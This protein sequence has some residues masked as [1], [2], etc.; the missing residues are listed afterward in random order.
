M[1]FKPYT[2]P[3]RLPDD[4]EIASEGNDYM[5]QV[6]RVAAA[7]AALLA[8][9]WQDGHTDRID[10]T[11]L[12]AGHDRWAQLADA[13]QFAMAEVVG[14]G[15][16]VAWPDGPDISARALATMAEVQRGWTG[17]EFSAWMARMGLS[18]RSAAEALA[19]APSTIHEQC[20]KTKIDRVMMLAARALQTDGIAFDA[21]S[22]P[23]RPGRP[24]R[25]TF[26]D[27]TSLGFSDVRGLDAELASAVTLAYIIAPSGKLFYCA[28]G[29]RLPAIRGEAPTAFGLAY[30]YRDSNGL[31]RQ[32]HV[33]LAHDPIKHQRQMMNLIPEV[34][35]CHLLLAYPLHGDVEAWKSSALAAFGKTD[36][37]DI[38]DRTDSMWVEAQ[39]HPAGHDPADARIR[40]NAGFGDTLEALDLELAKARN[41]RQARFSH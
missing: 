18:V 9:E 10:L 26:S 17:D 32:V 4:D 33:D 8:V 38:P 15:H 13:D 23:R 14:D 16:G 1:A 20:R 40:E 19:V 24:R 29:V 41:R 25:T 37:S 22:R 3:A 21:V 12:I 27:M 31:W 28:N 35:N 34:A 5:P 7:R 6:V 36:F 30:W 11:G 2:P 39:F